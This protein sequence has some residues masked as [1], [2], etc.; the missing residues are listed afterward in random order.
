MT[1][2]STSPGTGPGRARLDV[3]PEAGQDAA[4]G[5]MRAALAEHVG[6]DGVRLEAAIWIV[7][8]SQPD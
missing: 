1:R 3:V 8:A 4:L 2:P 7:T 6:P 5:D